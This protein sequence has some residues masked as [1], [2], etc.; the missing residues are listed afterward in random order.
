MLEE[1]GGFSS[2]QTGKPHELFQ[3]ASLFSCAIG[4]GE[5]SDVFKTC[6]NP[7]RRRSDIEQN[8]FGANWTDSCWWC[9]PIISRQDSG[10]ASAGGPLQKLLFPGLAATG[11]RPAGRYCRCLTIALLRTATSSGSRRPRTSSLA[12]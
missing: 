7:P 8:E 10:C 2:A 3:A 6:R 4:S 5:T 12:Q 1:G 9:Q 11:E